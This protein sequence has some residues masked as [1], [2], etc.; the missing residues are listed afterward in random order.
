MDVSILITVELKGCKNVT[1]KNVFCQDR[2]LFFP[3]LICVMLSIKIQAL[4]SACAVLPTE[5]NQGK[6]IHTFILDAT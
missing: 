5:I 3:K 2:K 1:V 4:E 6:F